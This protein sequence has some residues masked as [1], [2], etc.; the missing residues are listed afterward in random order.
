MCITAVAQRSEMERRMESHT[1]GLK[2]APRS[3]TEGKG[4]LR[5]R[6]VKY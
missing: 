1:T 5:A 4:D 2:L 6:T 3:A